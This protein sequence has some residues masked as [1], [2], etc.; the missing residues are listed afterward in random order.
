MQQLS[1]FLTIYNK[2]LTTQKGTISEENMKDDERDC[3]A[4]VINIVSHVVLFLLII[5]GKF[6]G[7]AGCMDRSN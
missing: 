5:L 1:Q 6:R 2:L 7:E 3:G 4:F